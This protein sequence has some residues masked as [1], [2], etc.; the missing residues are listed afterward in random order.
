MVCKNCGK[1]FTEKYSKWSNGDFCCRNCANSYNS[2]LNKG[3]TKIIKC[4]KCSKKIKVDI[5]ASN[6]KCKCDNCRGFS[7]P[8]KL[9]FCKYCGKK[10]IN[11]QRIYCSNKCKIEFEYNEFI[12]KWKNGKNDG[13]RGISDKYISYF[14]RKYIFEKFKSKCCKCGWSQ[15]NKFTNKIPLEIDHIDGNY[16]NNKEENLELLC[17]N[18]HSLTENYGSRNKGKGRRYFRMK[19]HKEINCSCGPAAKASL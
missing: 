1:E 9:D 17:P 18:C 12:Q 13:S 5:R 6:K 14:V 2:K 16:L 3:K 15:I 10:L 11:G 8:T 19:Y 4:C 7:L